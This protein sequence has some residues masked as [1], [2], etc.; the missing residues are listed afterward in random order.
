MRSSPCLEA[1]DMPDQVLDDCMPHDHGQNEVF[2]YVI[3][4]KVVIAIAGFPSGRT[5]RC[6][7]ATV[8]LAS[9]DGHLPLF[10]ILTMD[11]IKL[12]EVHP[13]CLLRFILIFPKQDLQKRH[14]LPL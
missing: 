13:L 6:R 8:W 2:L 9:L 12:K 3:D 4:L 7:L 1:S 11:K 5:C 10:D 14:H